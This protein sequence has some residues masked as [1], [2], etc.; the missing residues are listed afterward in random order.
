MSDKPIYDEHYYRA[1]GKIEKEFLD[2]SLPRP[3]QASAAVYAFADGQTPKVLLSIG[4]GV[5][6]LEQWLEPFIVR[7][8]GTDPSGAAETLYRGKEFHRMGFLRAL[9]QF[10]SIC[11]TII[12][13]E[14]IEHVEPDEF[15][16]A[17]EALKSLHVRLIITNRLA[18]HPIDLNDWDHVNKI[19]DETMNRIAAL[20]RVR[21]RHG[22]HIVVDINQDEH[23]T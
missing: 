6:I 4:A 9:K 19:D 11:N 23:G 15:R 17:L 10:G 16:A 18:Y 8:I 22:S 5:G 12:C 3:D 21:F 14:V 2:A 13:C 20:G 1:E 7:I